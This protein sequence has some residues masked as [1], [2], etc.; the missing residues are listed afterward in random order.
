MK[1]VKIVIGG[2]QYIVHLAQTDLEKE[3]GLQGV[4]ELPENQG[5]LFVFSEP[6]TQ[7]FWMEDTQIP[8]DIIFIND[9]LEVF[10]VEQGEPNTQDAHQQDNVSYVLEV[11]QGSGIKVG[12]ELEFSPEKNIDKSKMY[13]LGSDGNP[14]ME[15]EGGERIFSRTNT[16]TL[17]KFAKK[18][19]ST[20]NDNDYMNLGKRLFKFLK[21]QDEN[22]PEYVESKKQ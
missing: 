21:T 14:Q 19:Y 20:E 1:E 4:T 7:S 5:M 15:L 12:D 11:N 17:I 9:D 18:A 6:D 10:A 2:K 22:K 8:L 13:V 16:K 3:K